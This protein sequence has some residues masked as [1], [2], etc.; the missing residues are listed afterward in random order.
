MCRNI[1]ISCCSHKTSDFG[2]SSR[3]QPFFGKSG[4]IW[5][6]QFFCPNFPITATRNY[7]LACHQMTHSQWYYMSAMHSIHTSLLVLYLSECQSITLAINPRYI[8]AVISSQIQTVAR[9]SPIWRCKNS[10][11][12]WIHPDSDWNPGHP[13]LTMTVLLLRQF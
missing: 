2:H 11:Q 9:P 7:S 1:S 8:I 3:I 6:L 13:Q 10:N 5:L 4:H 12:I